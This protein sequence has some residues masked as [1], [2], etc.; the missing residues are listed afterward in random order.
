[1]ELPV[2]GEA[3]APPLVFTLL[4]QKF[5]DEFSQCEDLRFSATEMS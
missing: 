2:D 1:M 5:R 3:C 4:V